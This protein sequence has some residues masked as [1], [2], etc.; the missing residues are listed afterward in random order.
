MC[1]AFFKSIGITNNFD[2]FILPYLKFFGGLIGNDTLKELAAVINRKN[3]KL[4]LGYVVLPLKHQV[5]KQINNIQE[6]VSIGY[7]ND[8]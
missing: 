3:D 2:F 1:G 8:K 5:S 6:L 4:T 7:G